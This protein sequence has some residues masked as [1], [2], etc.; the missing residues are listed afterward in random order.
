M[1]EWLTHRSIT[2][3][4]FRLTVIDQI[5]AEKKEC[6]S[7]CD[8]VSVSPVCGSDGKVYPNSCYLQA[9]SCRRRSDSDQLRPAPDSLC[10]RSQLQ[11]NVICAGC[12]V[13]GSQENEDVRA[14][15]DF[16]NIAL[17]QHFNS[18]QTHPVWSLGCYCNKRC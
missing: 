18:R 9:A 4:A 10:A 8:K 16:A 14:A 12:P 2:S 13:E 15:A 7:G 6:P 5:C 11:D 17:T 3:S 1:S